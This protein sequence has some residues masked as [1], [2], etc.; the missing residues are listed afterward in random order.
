MSLKNN[1]NLDS[2]L[3]FDELYSNRESTAATIYRRSTLITATFDDF[4]LIS[5]VG[6]GTFGKVYLVRCKRNGRL[7]AMKQIR[8]DIVI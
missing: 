7:H 3:D 4:E 1:E 5:I 6:K 2:D 8:K